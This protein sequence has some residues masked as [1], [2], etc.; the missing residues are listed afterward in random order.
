MNQ[1][2]LKTES[3]LL[4]KFHLED[5]G[6]VQ[7]LAGN[8]NIS[9]TTLNIPYPYKTGMAEN[10][11]N[12]HQPNWESKTGV[13]YAI[14]LL[15]TSQLIGAIGLHD[16]K[17]TQAELGYWIGEHFWGEGYC[18]EAA[19]SLIE[20]SFINLGLNK[21]ISEHLTSNPASGKVME[22]AGMRYVKTIKNFDRHG[23]LADIKV[24]EIRN[25]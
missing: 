3:L 25:T 10:W 24:Y 14:T 20:F 19:R 21:V 18:T 4:R 15:E 11:I 9:K 13:V 23:E 5:A 16:I 12:T 7:R 6:E 17:S 22:K 2:E 8:N 1:P